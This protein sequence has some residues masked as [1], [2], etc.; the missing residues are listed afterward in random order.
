MEELH[1]ENEDLSRELAR[2]TAELNQLR[3][4][5][6]DSDQG[7]NPPRRRRRSIVGAE[8]LPEDLEELH[9]E[10]GNLAERVK[11]LEEENGSLHAKIMRHRARFESFSEGNGK[12]DSDDEPHVPE[13]KINAWKEKVHVLMKQHRDE[14]EGIIDEADRTRRNYEKQLE[15][16]D[17][18]YNTVYDEFV[19]LS[20]ELVRVE[21][22]R[23][24]DEA[25]RFHLERQVEELQIMNDAERQAAERSRREVEELTDQLMAFSSSPQANLSLVEEAEAETVQTSPV[26]RRTSTKHGGLL[27]EL[28]E[29]FDDGDAEL[30]KSPLHESLLEMQQVSPGITAAGALSVPGDGHLGIESEP[31]TSGAE[32]IAELKR[33]CESLQDELAAS[34]E[35][36]AAS[37]R[38]ELLL[39]EELDA[40]RAERAKAADALADEQGR[41]SA[42]L[43][44]AQKLSR[45]LEQERLSLAPGA[46]AGE[47]LAKAN[48]ACEQERERANA[49]REEA[50]KLA[51]QLEQ[52]RLRPAPGADVGGAE[53]WEKERIELSSQVEAQQKEQRGLEKR[54]AE[55]QG[56]LSGA[57]EMLRRWKEDAEN[58]SWSS[59]IRSYMCAARPPPPP[60]KADKADGLALN[61]PPPPPAE[62]LS[63]DGV[64]QALT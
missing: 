8:I 23:K 37:S 6:V 30:V 43:E 64:V 7:D 48:A 31:E 62:G 15:D 20:A 32:R 45:Q 16:A 36:A 34:K 13:K 53:A 56:E 49:A 54:V 39:R 57:K 51:R 25:K 3:R 2:V 4:G 46:D 29:E 50:Q 24:N 44:E 27:A 9:A 28:M 12:F 21:A 22:L 18:R 58:N 40:V 14:K 5:S 42:A 63:L 35:Q 47:E 11:L 60:S 61:G 10:N 1:R 59:T 19:R 41:A 52:Q 55:L 17:K 33:C 38:Q 26:V